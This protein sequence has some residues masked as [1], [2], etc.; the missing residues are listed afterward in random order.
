MKL[1]HRHL[2]LLAFISVSII[3]GAAA[4]ISKWSMQEV[5]PFMFSFLR[6]TLASLLILPFIY[7]KVA[8]KKE[9]IIKLLILGVFGITFGVGLLLAGIQLT[10]SIN[11]PIMNAVSPIFLV[12]GSIWFLNEKVKKRFILGGL[13]SLIG[14]LLITIQPLLITGPDGSIPGNLLVLLGILSSVVYTILLKKYQLPY[15]ALTIV[16]WVSLLGG[17]LLLPSALTEAILLKPFTHFDGKALIGI[18]YGTFFSS[19]VAF[20]LFTYGLKYL[21]ANETGIYIYPE[22]IATVAVAVPLL[23]EIIHPVYIVGTVIVFLGLIISEAPI[24]HRHHLHTHP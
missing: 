19:A 2:A 5:P 13:I 9:D 15:P 4:P 20:F 16:F 10:S 18:G 22:A 12:L 17:L 7:K 1:S 3:W 21:P 24:H 23:H 8:I 11:F 14:I 6:F